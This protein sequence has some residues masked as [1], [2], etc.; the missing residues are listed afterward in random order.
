MQTSTT[1]GGLRGL[2]TLAWHRGTRSACAHAMRGR[3]LLARDRGPPAD[4]SGLVAQVLV[5]IL[6]GVRMGRRLQHRGDG[7]QVLVAWVLLNR[8]PE[9][10]CV[11]SPSS[12]SFV[13]Q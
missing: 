3:I 10:S 13:I 8:P 12:A 5:T 4:I 7:F 11:I 1:K 2:I 6:L 9:L